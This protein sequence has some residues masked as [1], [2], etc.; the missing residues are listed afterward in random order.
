MKLKNLS[1]TLK[2]WELLQSDQGVRLYKYLWEGM[3]R[4]YLGTITTALS[5]AVESTYAASTAGLFLS[6]CLT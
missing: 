1:L 4:E 5:G 3:D 6:M 2:I